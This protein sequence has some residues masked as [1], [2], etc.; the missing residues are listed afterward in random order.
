MT[1]IYSGICMVDIPKK[2][3]R[4]KPKLYKTIGM[5]VYYKRYGH[6]YGNIIIDTKCR[7]L[8]GYVIYCTAKKLGV[9]DAPILMVTRRDRIKHFIKR[10]FRK[11]GK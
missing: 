2:M 8:D 5:E 11:V 7:L 6:F 1:R 10:H 9:Q 4:S 3:Q